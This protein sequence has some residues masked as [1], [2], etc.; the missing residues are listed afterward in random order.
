MDTH[1]THIEDQIELLIIDYL[2]GMISPR[3]LEILEQWIDESEEN[4]HHFEQLKRIWNTASLAEDKEFDSELAYN[5]FRIRVKEYQKQNQKKRRLTINPF[6]QGVAASVILFITGGLALYFI[7]AYRSESQQY[8]IT[9]PYGSKSK[10]TLPD[11]SI[12]W[13]NA[14]STLSYLSNFGRKARKVVLNGEAY[15]EV[16]KNKEKPFVVQGNDLAVRVL[17]TKFDVK[18][19]QED[20]IVD[21]T[22]LEG[23][24]SL[25]GRQK[26]SEKPVL[27]KPG[28]R[29]SY[30]K[31][32][33]RMVVAN[34]EATNSNA[35]TRGSLVFEEEKFGQIIK[36]LEREYNVMIEVKNKE[37]LERRFY[38]DF[39]RAQSITEIFDIMTESNKFHYRMMENK[40]EVYQ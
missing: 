3:D 15:F 24:V 29:A 8:S 25:T 12:V 18:S 31:Y 39:R 17:G 40:I 38:G 32:S 30:H 10:I 9:V 1:N 22:L 20:S 5:R 21:V 23:S 7:H 19:Y 37:L 11:N 16:S 6:L 27:I 26:E 4:R 2:G 33:Q 35:W 36:R 14:G 13:L 28:E 34:V